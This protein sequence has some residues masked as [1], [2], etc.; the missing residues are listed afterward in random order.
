MASLRSLSE[1]PGRISSRVS[2]ARKSASAFN[3]AARSWSAL[4]C[5]NSITSSLPLRYPI[6]LLRWCDV[7][8]RSCSRN[9]LVSGHAPHSWAATW[10]VPRAATLRS[11]R[12]TIVESP[13]D[14]MSMGLPTARG[15]STLRKRFRVQSMSPRRQLRGQRS[16]QPSPRHIPALAIRASPLLQV[17]MRATAAF[18]QCSADGKVN[19]R[20]NGVVRTCTTSRLTRLALAADLRHLR[21]CQR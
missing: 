3:W 21:G 9:R 15:L 16:E 4:A 10:S 19:V 20:Y 5:S 8:E 13:L 18:H 17:Q 14:M 6:R 12:A 7:T 11:L 1:S 2:T